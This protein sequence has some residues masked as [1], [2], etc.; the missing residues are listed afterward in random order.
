MLQSPRCLGPPA[1][2]SCLPPAQLA[3]PDRGSAAARLSAIINDFH[4]TGGTHVVAGLLSVGA[5]NIIVGD[6]YYSG[7]GSYTL[8]GGSLQV[9]KLTLRGERFEILDAPAEV[10]ILDRIVLHSTF[11]AVPGSTIRFDGADLIWYHGNMSDVTMVF[12][13]CDQVSRVRTPFADNGPAPEAFEGS[14]LQALELGGPGGAGRIQIAAGAEEPGIL[15]TE[16]LILNAGAW[17]EPGSIIYYLN[18]G[19]PKQFFH[20]DATLDGRVSVGD[21]CVLAGNWGL[22]EG[23]VWAEGVRHAGFV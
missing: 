20:G 15:Y 1:S 14:A 13:N 7:L 2:P 10:R 11:E 16:N 19:E 9:G 17:I 23:A 3:R 6:D 4:Q 18:G 21:L 8:S 22:A 5:D 12:E